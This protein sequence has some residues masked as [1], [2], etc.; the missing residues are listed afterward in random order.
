MDKITR[1]KE[2]AEDNRE[3]VIGFLRDLIE[4]PSESCKEEQVVE[5]IRKEMLAVGFDEVIT[6]EMGS[7][8]GRIG[9]G[10][11]KILYDSHIDTVGIGNKE[12]WKFDPYKGKIKNDI[13]YG[14]GASDNK[15]AISTMVYGAKLIKQL[16]ENIDY[17]LYVIG[18]VQEEDCDGL[19]MY[20]LFTETQIKPDYIVLGECTD[21]DIYR[22]HRG[23]MEIQIDVRGQSAH[24]SAPERGENAI[25]KASK[26]ALEIEQLNERL[27]DDPFLGK[28]TIAVTS[29][30]SQS[31]SFNTIPDKATIYMDRRLTFGEDKESSIQELQALESFDSQT[32]TIEIPDYSK[33]SYKGTR[34]EQEKYFPTWMLPEDHPLVIAGFNAAKAI[35]GEQPKISKWVFSTNGVASMGRLNIPTI[36]FG[37]SEEKFAHSTDDQVSVEHLVKSVEFYAAFP[38]Y[39]LKQID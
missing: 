4:I 12:M 23:R 10:P 28:G 29:F 18:T 2:L 38:E 8:V 14:R 36:G 25:Y 16:D 37:P 20:K 17:T 6:D 30:S 33:K 31:G 21:L 34:A 39:L 32:M 3:N 5:R 27:T 13:V 22:G 9:N 35:R 15:A 11:I 26:L 7:I 19:A 1:I 24:A